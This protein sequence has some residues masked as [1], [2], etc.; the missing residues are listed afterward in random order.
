MADMDQRDF[1][2]LMSRLKNPAGKKDVD[3]VMSLFHFSKEFP[4]SG[5]IAIFA[6][7]IFDMTNY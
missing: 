6:S 7:H 2:S 4:N 5:M 1:A 3:A